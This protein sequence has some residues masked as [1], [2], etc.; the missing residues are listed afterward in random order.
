MA[1]F[2]GVFLADTSGIPGVWIVVAAYDH[3][4]GSELKTGIFDVD[5]L[6]LE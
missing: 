5:Q 4:P 3:K 6:L 2:C 1:G